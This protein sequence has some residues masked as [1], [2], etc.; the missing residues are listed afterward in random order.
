M[1][2]LLD[3]RIVC[4][5]LKLAYVVGALVLGFVIVSL[6]ALTRLPDP[7][8]GMVRFGI[9]LTAVLLGA[10]TFR[11]R[12]EPI[13]PPRAPW[14]MTARPRLSQVL[15]ILFAVLFVGGALGML[16]DALGVASGPA[17]TA[18]TIAGN[19]IALVELALI[20]ALYLRS[21]VRLRRL[22]VPPKDPKFKPTVR[23]RP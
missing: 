13:E 7:I 12:G 10:R 19:V 2:R 22:G 17:G 23:I 21:A 14:R 11:G 8:I 4:W 16:F 6:L 5:E 3:L 15:G 9:D 1:R 20:A 18:G